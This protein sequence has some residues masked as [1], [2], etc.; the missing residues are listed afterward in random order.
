[1]EIQVIVNLFAKHGI[2]VQE[3]AI[4]YI[5]DKP[6]PARYVSFLTENKKQL[7]LIVTKKDVQNQ[8]KLMEPDPD[9]T[10]ST[11]G[12]K[13]D[14]RLLQGPPPDDVIRQMEMAERGEK[15]TTK[16]EQKQKERPP[17]TTY[18]PPVAQ[19][20]QPSS[21]PVPASVEEPKPELKKPSL[22]KRPF[23]EKNVL[24]VKNGYNVKIN[25]GTKFKPLS[26][27]YESDIKIHED[28]TG[29][30]TCVGELSDFKNYFCERFDAIS[31]IIRNGKSDMGG[32]V[33]IKRA[34]MSTGEVK[35]L[36]MVT[37]WDWTKNGHKIVTIEDKEDNIK[38]L[39]NKK[40]PELIKLNVINDEV[41]GVIGTID[42]KKEMIFSDKLIWPEIPRFRES[43]MAEVPLSAAFISDIHLGSKTFLS[44]PWNKF[45]QWLNGNSDTKK[46]LELLSSLKYLVVVGDLVDGIGIYPNQFDDLE[47]PDI[48]EQYESL[49]YELDRIPDHIEVI[50]LPGNHDAVRPAEPQPALPPMVTERFHKEML[51]VGNPCSMSLSGVDVL[52]Y[53]GRSIDDF[54]T[55]FE[56]VSYEKPLEAMKEM[57]NRRNLL[58]MY[59][60]KTPIAPEARDYMTIR[61]VPDIF[62][63]GHVHTYGAKLYRDVI[64]INSST[65]QAQTGFQKMMN[66]VPDPAKV[67]VV[68]LQTKKLHQMT[69]MG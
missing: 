33:T 17:K 64:M 15:N 68:N 45:I 60:E 1:M 11:P 50:L 59:G 41:I 39:I 32:A 61:K 44:E 10:P 2:L 8:E 40:N 6:D 30:S 48:Y 56:H 9:E 34:K 69:F 22:E 55:T 16:M 31:K 47:I 67:P 3:E 53:H 57:L 49:S 42:R 5:K 52:A 26:K 63:T 38:V 27:E 20:A 18:Q 54:V 24:N 65:W 13:I 58:P 29:N 25:L 35:V 66:F 62:V 36:G 28:I 21:K 37:N 23:Q 43:K 7:P 46:E 12:E 14:P 19:P 51:C 4:Q